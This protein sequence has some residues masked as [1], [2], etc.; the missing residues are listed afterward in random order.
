MTAPKVKEC[1]L[2]GERVLVKHPAWY[3]HL[4]GWQVHLTCVEREGP[5]WYKQLLEKTA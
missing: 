1:A 5:G 4:F 3:S 2:C